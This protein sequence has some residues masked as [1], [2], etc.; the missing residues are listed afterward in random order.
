MRGALHFRLEKQ[1]INIIEGYV[2]DISPI[3]HAKTDPSK[4]YFDLSFQTDNKNVRACL[5]VCFSPEKWQHLKKY[6]ENST[7]CVISSIVQDSYKT[8][9]FKLTNFSTIK[10]KTLVFSKEANYQFNSL[11]EIINEF[12]LMELVNVMV[13]IVH[14]GD[15]KT[16]NNN[17]TLK[18]YIA[19]DDGKFQMK[20]AVFKQFADQMELNNTYKILNLPL[21]TYLNERKLRSTT[22]N[23]VDKIDKDIPDLKMKECLKV[24]Q[25]EIV[26]FDNADNNSLLEH[27]SC[28]KCSASFVKTDKKLVTCTNCGGVQLSKTCVS[29]N[30]LKLSKS[31]VLTFVIGIFYQKFYHQT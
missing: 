2:L 11:D 13:R 19:K 7:G 14:A 15:I 18:E 17:L 12:Q 25:R 24:D 16:T 22:L 29:K 20:I 6:Q 1:P 10:P 23:K 28:F 9:E 8:N 30:V 5:R 31:L 3:K 4:T 26:I 21:V 27:T